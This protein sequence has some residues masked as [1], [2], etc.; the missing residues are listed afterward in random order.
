MFEEG[1]KIEWDYG[2][3]YIKLNLPELSPSTEIT[4]TIQIWKS[5]GS[6]TQ[7]NVVSEIS[8]DDES[9]KIVLT[10][11]RENNTE[12]ENEPSYWG[13]STINIRPE[14]CVATWAGTETKEFDGEAKVT[15]LPSGLTGQIQRQT[16]SRIQREQQQ[17]RAALLLLDKVCAITSESY[18][19]V[20]DA[21][22]IIAAKRGGREIIENAVLLRADVH[23]LLDSGAISIRVD[24]TLEILKEL[25]SGY[26]ELLRDK[27][28]AP[29][30]HKRVAKALEH[31]ENAI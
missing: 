3:E 5:D 17:L 12:I 1:I 24:G 18:A 2:H 29:I 31:L 14:E 23:R 4:S 21:A 7:Y 15:K 22:H 28:L 25:P 26:Q 16:I 11:D 9:F 30:V 13:T 10:Y 8:S 20:L 19:D 27:R 6:A